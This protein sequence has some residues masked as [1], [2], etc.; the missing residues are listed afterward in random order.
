MLRLL[1]RPLH[2]LALRLGDRLRKQWWRRFHPKLHGC[3]VIALDEAGRVLLVRHSYGSSEWSFPTGS[4]KRGEHPE[5]AARREFTEETGA[6]IAELRTLSIVRDDLFGAR[7]IQHVFVGLV[8]GGAR[9]DGRE[10]AE[11][12]FFAIDTLPRQVSARALALLAQI[13]GL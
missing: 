5:R 6:V 9:A 7:H 3:C 11:L 1:P 4:I 10:I 2:R 13:A 12:E 8:E